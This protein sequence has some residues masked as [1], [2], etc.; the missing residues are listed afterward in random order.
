[1]PFIHTKTN[2]SIS[3]AVRQELTEGLGKAIALLP[4]KS[5]QWLMLQFEDQC[6]MAFQGKSDAPV[7]M[8]SVQVYGGAP[9]PCYDRLTGAITKLLHEKLSISPDHVY[10]AYSETPNWGWNGQNF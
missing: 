9:D 10:V 5:E 7:A 6:A 8:V 1:M 3:P 2:A 4:G